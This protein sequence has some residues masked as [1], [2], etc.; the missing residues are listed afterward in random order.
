MSFICG[1]TENEA[2]VEEDKEA[3]RYEERSAK[4]QEII[5]TVKF[6]YLHHWVRYSDYLILHPNLSIHCNWVLPLRLIQLS[7]P[8]FVYL[9]IVLVVM[10]DFASL[11]GNP[12]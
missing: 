7:R 1:I 9:T 6:R 2:P 8:H 4:A 5:G 10:P 11:V 3:R 12:S